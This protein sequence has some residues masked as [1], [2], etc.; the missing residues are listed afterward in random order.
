MNSYLFFL[1][2]FVYFSKFMA[3]FLS[4]NRLLTWSRDGRWLK[5][6]V[7]APH[8]LGNVCVKITS[9]WPPAIG[10]YPW[11]AIILEF[12]IALSQNLKGNLCQVSVSHPNKA[13]RVVVRTSTSLILWN[14]LIR[15]REITL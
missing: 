6:S 3:I 1:F 12:E 7:T 10:T 11:L 4:Q 8:T 2:V 15:S 13:H 9:A 14:K 5:P